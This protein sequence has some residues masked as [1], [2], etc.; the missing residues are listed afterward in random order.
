MVTDIHISRIETPGM[1][2]M[3][4]CAVTIRVLPFKRDT[5]GS[6]GKTK[7]RLFSCKDAIFLIIVTYYG[8]AGVAFLSFVYNSPYREGSAT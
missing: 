7:V 1:A 5:N 4:S 8:D 2:G 6:Y 3:V